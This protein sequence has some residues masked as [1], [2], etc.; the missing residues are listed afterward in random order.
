MGGELDNTLYT[1]MPRRL[2]SN[3]DL[4]DASLVI[5]KPFPVVINATTNELSETVTAGPNET[6]QPFRN[7]R[8]TLIRAD[9][10]YEILTD[11]KFTFTN[12]NNKPVSYT[13]LTLPP[14]LLE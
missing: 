12:S 2:V 1:E 3:V 7:D 5:R 14:I 13:H 6:F 9:G 8:Y 10:T 4:T 11:D